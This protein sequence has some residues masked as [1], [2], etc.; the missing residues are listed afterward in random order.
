MR[1]QSKV[2]LQRLTSLV[3][4]AMVQQILLWWKERG[5]IYVLFVTKHSFQIFSPFHLEMFL[6]R[7]LKASL[8]PPKNSLT[9]KRLVSVLDKMLFLTSSGASVKTGIKKGL[10]TLNRKD[11]PW[12]R[13][14]YHIVLNWLLKTG[15]KWMDPSST[16]F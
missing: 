11:K 6:L 1:R 12:I 16:C 4:F 13:F 3:S 15:S 10:I 7:M 9:A 2:K 14:A 8:V 5:C